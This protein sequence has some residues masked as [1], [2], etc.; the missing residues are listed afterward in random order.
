MPQDSLL[1]AF[2][3]SYYLGQFVNPSLQAIR[4]TA[5]TI[6]A[7]TVC[8][9]F[10]ETQLLSGEV[11]EL[12]FHYDFVFKHPIDPHFLILIEET[13]RGIIKDGCSLIEREMMRENA[14]DFL[15]HR[16]QPLKAELVAATPYNIVRLIELNGFIDTAP[17][18]FTDT[19][20]EAN[21]FK[22]LG[23][24]TITYHLPNL[25]PFPA[26]RFSGIA[27]HDKQQLKQFSKR[28]KIEKSHDHRP[29]ISLMELF[30]TDENLNSFEHTWLPKGI[31]VSENLLNLWRQ[32]A[33]KQQAAIVSTPQFVNHSLLNKSETFPTEHIWLETTDNKD[34]Y[35]PPQTP[36]LAHALLF[37]SKSRHISEL[38]IRYTEIKKIYTNPIIKTILWGMLK[39][40]CYQSDFTHSFC[41]N[42]QLQK[43]IISSLQ[44][45]D[46]IVTILGFR[47]QWNLSPQGTK[48][49]G[50]KK[51]WSQTLDLMCQALEICD[52]DYNQEPHNSHF[53][54][55]KIE[56]K[57]L[58]LAERAWPGPEIAI[59]FHVPTS[60]GLSY[61]NNKSQKAT[62]IMLRQ[63]IFGPLERLIALL[64]EKEAGVLPLWLTPEQVR[65]IAVDNTQH[66]YVKT[67][68]TTLQ[69][70]GFRA[71]CDLRS[72]PQGCSLGT[73]IH[74]V[75]NAKVPYA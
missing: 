64:I 23:F 52:F 66:S 24:E 67:L 27:F 30:S 2:L 59:D 16:N 13:M 63:S 7:Y 47:C 51:Q 32:V 74:D 22:L 43:E 72:E 15:I 45:I 70:A 26:I 69:Q 48:Y 19:T 6:L 68:L 75:E 36:A 20:L 60:L 10:P 21:A 37:K 25:E 56:V 41:T 28:Q 61:T 4:G 18:W 40:S 5:S 71:N 33:L 8:Q 54:G 55:P 17:R 46:R 14:V 34:F 50:T 38:P 9:L 29:L 53:A 39:T 12:G 3:I 49:A 31:A 58:D 11:H 73:R 42:E 1:I 57:L 65:V 62:P 44:F 35:T